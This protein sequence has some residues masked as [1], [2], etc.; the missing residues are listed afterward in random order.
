MTKEYKYNNVVLIDDNEVDNLINQKLMKTTKF[1]R[2][3]YTYT[4]G[5][6][7]LEFFKN[8]DKNPDFPSEL[9]P[10]LV[11]LDINMPLMNGFLFIESFNK[12]SKRVTENTKIIILTSSANPQDIQKASEMD[13][14]VEYLPKPLNKEKLL[15]VA[16]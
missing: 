15:Q 13:V 6:S 8:I 10:D 3:I 14:V 5:K 9:I 7:A 2:L 1:A 11:L 12:L 16:N 4:S